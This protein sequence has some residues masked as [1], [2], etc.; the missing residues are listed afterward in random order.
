VS[1]CVSI[2]ATS[3]SAYSEV[4]LPEK[5]VSVQLPSG[6]QYSEDASVDGVTYDLEFSGPSSLGHVPHGYLL[7]W[8]W[9][10]PVTSE[11]LTAELQA[12]LDEVSGNPSYS[13]FYMDSDIADRTLNGVTSVDASFFVGIGDLETDGYYLYERVVLVVSENWDMAWRLNVSVVE[14]MFLSYSITIKNIINSL[15]IDEEDSGSSLIWLP[16]AVIVVVVIAAAV[17]LWRWGHRRDAAPLRTGKTD[18]R[19]ESKPPG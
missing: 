19:Q 16:L 12:Y 1:I 14:G 8:T 3:A 7:S 18:V 9:S 2:L 13:D 4:R 5:H 17:M 10:S 6:W 11:A 15:T